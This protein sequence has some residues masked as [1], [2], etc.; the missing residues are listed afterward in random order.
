MGQWP[1]H[2]SQTPEGFISI[3]GVLEGAH[4][5]I[6]ACGFGHVSGH[7]CPEWDGRPPPHQSPPSV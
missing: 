5:S 2:L 6:Y 7:G 4:G 3:L 1:L